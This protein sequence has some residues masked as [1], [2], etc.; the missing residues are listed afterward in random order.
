MAPLDAADATFSDPLLA[1]IL[2]SPVGAKASARVLGDLAKDQV[3]PDL[4]T[5]QVVPDRAS[6]QVVPDRASVQVVPDMAGV[7][8][9]CITAFNARPASNRLPHVQSR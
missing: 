9:I 8:S 3:V 4:A 2:L 7:P 1:G 6:V 5:D